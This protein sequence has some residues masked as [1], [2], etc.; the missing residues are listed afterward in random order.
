MGDPF[1][2]M[3]LTPPMRTSEAAAVLVSPVRQTAAA[4]GGDDRSRV[5]TAECSAPR[6]GSLLDSLRL[7]REDVPLEGPSEEWFMA[8]APAV[9]ALERV[10]VLHFPDVAEWRLPPRC[11]VVVMALRQL[12]RDDAAS[13]LQTAFDDMCA[14]E[15]GCAVADVCGATLGGGLSLGDE[16]MEELAAGAGLEDKLRELY[17]G[18]PFLP[19]LLAAAAFYRAQATRSEGAGGAGGK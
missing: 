5:A 4:C 12:G 2:T 10:V 3:H 1:G 8:V 11:E 14:S 7:R 6:R 18:K 17:D 9:A 13:K 16:Y 19:T 15:D